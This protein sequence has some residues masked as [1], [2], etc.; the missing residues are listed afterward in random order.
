MLSLFHGKVCAGML[1]LRSE[2]NGVLAGNGI[3]IP[4]EIVGEILRD[5]SCL[6]RVLIAEA[7]NAHQGI[8]DE[9]RAHLKYHDTRALIGNLNKLQ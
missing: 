2:G 3:K 7:V 8:V 6:L 1:K 4:A 5:P 9:M